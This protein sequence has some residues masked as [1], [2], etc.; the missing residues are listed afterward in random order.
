MMNLN[1][2]TSSKYRKV[3]DASGFRLTPRRAIVMRILHESDGHLDA[4]EIWRLAQDQDKSVNLATVYRTLAVF[5]KLGLVDQRYF[6][7]DH[8]RVNYETAGKH[9]HY[10]FTC[11]GCG[12]VIE[13]ETKRIN[14]AQHELTEMLGLRFVDACVCFEGYCAECDVEMD[15]SFGGTK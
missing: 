10:H 6:A 4:Q 2:S 14:Q 5:K 12:Q 3:L 9:E 8:K 13:I 11:L 15:E 1:N 7:R